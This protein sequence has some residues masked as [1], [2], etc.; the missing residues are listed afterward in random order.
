MYYAAAVCVPLWVHGVCA[1]RLHAGKSRNPAG[2]TCLLL[3]LPDG[4]GIGYLPWVPVGDAGENGQC[5]YPGKR[6]SVAAAIAT[7]WVTCG[8]A[9]R[10]H[11]LLNVQSARR[12]V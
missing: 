3:G 1:T 9:V 10:E 6:P 11:R 7:D 8:W 5:P 12:R 4:G 2:E